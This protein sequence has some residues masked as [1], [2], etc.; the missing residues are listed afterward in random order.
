[1]YLKSIKSSQHKEPFTP[2]IH[3]SYQSLYQFPHAFVHSVCFKH[4]YE[5]TTSHPAWQTQRY[6]TGCD[7][8]LTSDVCHPYYHHINKLQSK[9]WNMILLSLH[10]VVTVDVNAPRHWQH[11]IFHQWCGLSA[12][13]MDIMSWLLTIFN[14]FV[15]F[16]CS[17]LA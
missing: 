2:L 6:F 5:M 12:T 7:K 11:W 3:F 8:W 14:M 1:M 16:K 10:L 4:N 17:S 15:L 9:L 13:T